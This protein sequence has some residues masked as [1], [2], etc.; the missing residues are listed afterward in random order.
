M[1]SI[2]VTKF[3]GIFIY[4][5]CVP[6]P[7]PVL[8]L[9]DHESDPDVGKESSEMSSNVSGLNGGLKCRLLMLN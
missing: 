9:P 4:G 8:L 3:C 7:V 6:V 2:A 5:G 1:F